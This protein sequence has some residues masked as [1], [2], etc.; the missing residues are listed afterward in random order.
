VSATRPSVAVVATEATGSWAEARARDLTGAAEVTVVKAPP[1]D[2]AVTPVYL[3]ESYAFYRRLRDSTFDSIVFPDRGGAAYC[4]ARA[5][6][7]GVAFASTAIVVD[8]IGPSARDLESPG[9][10]YLTRRALGVAVTER[11]A[12]ELADG[13]VCD[14]E[15]VLRW[16]EESG[17]SLPE[18]DGAGVQPVFREKRAT[19]SV[20]PSIAVVVSTRERP[21]YLLQCLDGIGGQTLAPR[22]VIVADDGS[23]SEAAVRAL[24]EAEARSWPWPLRVLRLERG[25]AGSARNG[26]WRAASSDLVVFI[27]D[28]DVPF[29]EL[30]GTLWR[31]RIHSGADVV[32]AGARWFRGDGPPSANAGDV[33]RVSL[34]DPGEL[35]LLSNQY[36]GPTNLWPRELLERLGG[37]PEVPLEDWNL[38]ARAALAGARLTTPPD[39]LYWYRQTPESAYTA[40]TIGARDAALPALADVFAERLPAE[41]RLLPRMAAGAYAELDRRKATSAGLVPILRR[42]VRRTIGRG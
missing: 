3:A 30:L 39:P 35:G 34:C 31:A 36:G 14:D 18:R 28:D 29:E 13:F 32:V 15:G 10:P 25:G 23:T 6:E 37:F 42:A 11:L 22:E 24:E 20:E 9:R 2:V 33:L 17:W 40:D 19:D 4:C 7:T 12:L 21:H 41:L 26:G 27:D 16:L 5:R 1:L 8:C 38:L